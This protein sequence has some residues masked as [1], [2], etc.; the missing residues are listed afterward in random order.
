MNDKYMFYNFFNIPTSG[1]RIINTYSIYVYKKTAI[2]RL[3][4]AEQ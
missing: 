2:S 4:G 1:N 3:I